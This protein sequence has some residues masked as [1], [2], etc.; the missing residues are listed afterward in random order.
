MH[1]KCKDATCGNQTA[2]LCA[3]GI[4]Y[5]LLVYCRNIILGIAYAA[6][7][8]RL[9]LGHTHPQSGHELMFQVYKFMIAEA[10]FGTG[11]K[12]VQWTL[13]HMSGVLFST[14]NSK[15]GR[16]K[17]CVSDTDTSKYYRCEIYVMWL[18]LTKYTNLLTECTQVP[19]DSAVLQQSYDC[20]WRC[21]AG[22]QQDELMHC[23]N[24]VLQQLHAAK[25]PGHVGTWT[26]TIK[27]YFFFPV[28][29][30]ILML[31][32]LLLFQLMHNQFPLKY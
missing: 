23:S 1:R 14:V 7:D 19:P 26:V 31:S 12:Q 6:T 21:Q 2:F 18:S 32:S 13:G 11:E 24:E 5:V 25:S 30:C 16:R 28:V 15:T 29:P 3:Y 22:R 4:P 8:N 20:P 10:E 9:S 27:H 17:V